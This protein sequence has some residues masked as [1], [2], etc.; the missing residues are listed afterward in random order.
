MSLYLLIKHSA[1]D[2]LQALFLITFW[3]LIYNLYSQ[4]IYTYLIANF[5]TQQILVGIGYLSIIGGYWLLSLLFALLDLTS[6]SNSLRI[7]KVQPRKLPSIDWYWKA[8]KYIVFLQLVVN[9]P[10]SVFWGYFVEHIRG[11]KIQNEPVPS[12]ATALMHLAVFAVCEEIGFYYTHRLLHTAPLYKRIHKRHHEF[13]APISI[14]G[15]S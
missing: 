4:Q 14:A 1:A 12:I 9:L 10:V 13:T 11:R 7:Y 6:I 5:S 8:A 3:L 2:S 15:I